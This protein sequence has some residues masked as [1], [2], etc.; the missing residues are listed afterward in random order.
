MQYKRRFFR[1]DESL[2]GDETRVNSGRDLL[3]RGRSYALFGCGLFIA[4][5]KFFTLTARARQADADC[6][7][8]AAVELP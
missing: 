5:E 6:V 1:I 4:T 8:A 7:A 2:R 3:Y